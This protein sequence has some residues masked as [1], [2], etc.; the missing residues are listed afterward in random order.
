MRE[1]LERFNL[2]Q[3]IA[4]IQRQWR[5]LTEPDMSLEFRI[6]RKSYGGNQEEW[7]SESARKPIR[8]CETFNEAMTWVEENKGKLAHQEGGIVNMGN[9][10][11]EY[12]II[13]EVC[14]KC[15]SRATVYNPRA[16]EG[17]VFTD[18]V[19]ECR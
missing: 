2:S 10:Y 13:E 16:K 9:S 1:F 7:H 4:P 5:L 19:H 14:P 3:L 17:E 12:Y 11:H 6:Y 15:H 18:M 8:S